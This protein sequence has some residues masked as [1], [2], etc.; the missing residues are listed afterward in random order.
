MQSDN[1]SVDLPEGKF[2]GRETFRG[3]I[4]AALAEA[5]RA[6]WR[7]LIV[8]DAS[9]ADWPLSDR[10]TIEALNAWARRGQSFTMLAKGYGEVT[11]Q[12]ARFVE[13]RRLWSH[14][15]DCRVCPAAD[16]LDMPSA[17]WSPVWI[18]QRFDTV[19][20]GGVSG[21]EPERQAVLRESIEGWLKRSSAGFPATTLGL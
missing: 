1:N 15:I 12:H 6:G 10:D 16:P 20:S 8:S 21:R 7:E 5:A 18:L 2:L 11:R 17:L 3:L 19:L 14:K 9:F 4:R 13:W